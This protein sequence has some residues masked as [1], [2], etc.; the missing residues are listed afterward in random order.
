MKEQI[1]QD[2]TAIVCVTPAE[3]EPLTN[4]AKREVWILALAE[5]PV[6]ISVPA[7]N[8]KY[9]KCVMPSGTELVVEVQRWK[10]PITGDISPAAPIYH[11][12]KPGKLYRR[13]PDALGEVLML[14]MDERK[15]IK[16]ENHGA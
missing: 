15:R 10:N 2:D 11:I 9:I 14:I 3:L 1:M 4:K 6:W 16:E 12:V 7:L 8:V 13:F 5:R